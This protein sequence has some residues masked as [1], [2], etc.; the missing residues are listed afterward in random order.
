MIEQH[1]TYDEATQSW[2][3]HSARRREIE[4]QHNFIQRNEGS[5]TLSQGSLAKPVRDAKKTAQGEKRLK[6]AAQHA[7]NEFALVADL[8][9][10]PSK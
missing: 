7:L 9:A 10:Q 3:I 4:G 8:I 1:A 5:M 6:L 2:T